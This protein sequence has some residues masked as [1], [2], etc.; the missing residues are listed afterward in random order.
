MRLSQKH[1]VNPCMSECYICGEVK[2]IVL[3]GLAGERMA[4]EMGNA[5]GEMP[6]Q[7]VFSVDPCDKC[8][9]MGIAFIEMTHEGRD[10]RPTGR[11]C[12]LKEEA[13]HRMLE[14]GSLLDQIL[15]KRATFLAPE[16]WDKM[17]FSNTVKESAL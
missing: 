9:E 15:A 3:T 4:R 12:L 11:R 7:A 13:V 6:R 1:G 16:A 10:A 5:D 14:P 2:E 8:K 17:G